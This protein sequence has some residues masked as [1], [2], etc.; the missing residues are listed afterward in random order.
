VPSRGRRGGRE[1]LFD[2]GGDFRVGFLCGLFAGFV[3][4][5]GLVDV[6]GCFFGF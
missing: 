4:G 2:W 1:G 5:E 6:G 3:F